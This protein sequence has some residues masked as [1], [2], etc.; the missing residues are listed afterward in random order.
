[1]LVCLEFCTAKSCSMKGPGW[2]SSSEKQA[3]VERPIATHAKIAG[4]GTDRP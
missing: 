1:M 3:V 2:V 4:S